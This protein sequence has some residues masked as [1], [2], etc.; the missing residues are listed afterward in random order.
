ML[1]ARGGVQEGVQME[2]GLNQESRDVGTWRNR[3]PGL[4]KPESER[5]WGAKLE[6]VEGGQGLQG[7][8]R[9]L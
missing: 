2:G 9:I 4:K 6:K 8:E 3:N 1:G 5:G 7:G